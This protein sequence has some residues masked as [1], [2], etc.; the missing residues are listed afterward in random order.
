MSLY[1]VAWFFNRQKSLGAIKNKNCVCQHQE[2]PIKQMQMT[3]V[4]N[5]KNSC[6]A[7][8]ISSTCWSRSIKNGQNRL[9]SAG[10]SVFTALLSNKFYRTRQLRDNFLNLL[11]VWMGKLNVIWWSVTPHDLQVNSSFRSDSS[12]GSTDIILTSLNG[13]LKAP[14]S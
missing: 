8:D 1:G 12:H 7:E 14:S 9:S 13:K 6:T 3:S 10:S 2:V 4:W 11:S 5:K